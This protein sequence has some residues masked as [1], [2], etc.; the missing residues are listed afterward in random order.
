MSI[1][2]K[3]NK[4]KYITNI[5]LF[6]KDRVDILRYDKYYVRLYMQLDD[7]CVRDIIDK[8]QASTTTTLVQQLFAVSIS[9]W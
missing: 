1:Q 5:F 8:L 4:K 3:I 7:L 6:N 2:H 9:P